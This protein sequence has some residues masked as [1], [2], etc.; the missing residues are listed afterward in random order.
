MAVS[1][2]HH[3]QPRCSPRFCVSRF[4]ALVLALLALACGGAKPKVEVP[5]PP[6]PPVEPMAWLPSDASMVGR[7]VLEPWRATPVWGAWDKVQNKPEAWPSW[8]DI[9]LVSEIS[10]GGKSDAERRT[11]FVA[12]L[13]G[14]FGDGYLAKL[15]QAEPT[16]TEVHGAWTMYVRGETRW[17]Q[18][19]AT[20]LVVCSADY[21]AEVAARATRGGE[22]MA[23]ASGPL[24]TSLNER[25]QFMA[26]DLALMAEDASGES[27]RLLQR[28]GQQLGLA[29]ITEELVRAGL[30]VDLGTTV[31]LVAAAEAQGEQE[32]KRLEQSVQQTL[33]V[34]SRNLFV[35][36]LG[37]K[38]VVAALRASAEGS[39]VT[40][41]G[42]LAEADVR[43]LLSKAASML[44]VAAQQGGALRLS[45]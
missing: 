35:G 38:P 15:A 34:L 45:P 9:A 4:A 14:R 10:I 39:H 20:T 21:A 23:V 36:L 33:E 7:I 25:L 29:P 5:E 3:R 44:E 43:A 37:L 19:S 40:V 41:R 26:A 18:T 12:G 8:I 16:A 32:A 6:K 30:S 27:Q 17:L 24:F 2:S 31:S 42:A 13:K 1:T 11:S 28:Q 22:E